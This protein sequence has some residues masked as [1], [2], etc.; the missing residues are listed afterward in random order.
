MTIKLVYKQE[1]PLPP[2]M[3]ELVC[4]PTEA[5]PFVLGGNYI[6]SQKY[7]WLT[8]DDA[9]KGRQLLNLQGA[10][11]LVGCGDAIVDAINKQTRLFD[12]TMNGRVYIRTGEGTLASPYV[13]EPDIPDPMTPEAYIE[14]G[15]HWKQDD[16]H[17]LLD[18]F[19]N[20]AVSADYA[21]DRNIRQQLDDIKALLEAEDSEAAL[22]VLEQ[23]LLAL[24]GAL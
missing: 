19:A 6:R 18:N 4:V 9:I 16:T 13:Y 20:G 12:A 2:Y 21:D 15:M 10:N 23:I 1:A 7:W 3:G 22:E 24:G 14:P 5:V 8:S 17:K 11:M